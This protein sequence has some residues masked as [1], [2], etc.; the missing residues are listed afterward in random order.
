MKIVI[1]GGPGTGKTALIDQLKKKGFLVV[2]EIIRE[3]TQKLSQDKIENQGSNPLEMAQNP[4]DFNR[5]LIKARIDQYNKT[6]GV[7]DI[8]FFDR[9]IPDVLAYMNF[10]QQK[11]PEEFISWT[12]THVYD[13]VF[14]LPPWKEIYQTD[15][16]RFESFEQ[17]TSLYDSLSKTY[18]DLGY[19]IVRVPIGTIEERIKIIFNH[20]TL[21][22]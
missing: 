6:R 21:L 1:T 9:G 18:E 3:L 8:V 2:P 13:K 14:I 20:M 7:Q 4:I 11:I 19:P 16:E 15:A 17:A 5:S 22:S 12:S 10:F